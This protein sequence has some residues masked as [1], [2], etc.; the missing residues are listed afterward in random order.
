MEA[1]GMLTTAPV[2]T[3]ASKNR[4]SVTDVA[5]TELARKSVTIQWSSSSNSGPHLVTFCLFALCWPYQLLLAPWTVL[6]AL[7]MSNEW[8]GR[9]RQMTDLIEPKSIF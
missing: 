2:L 6:N 9:G 3:C 8:T 7:R 5:Q 1:V 4:G